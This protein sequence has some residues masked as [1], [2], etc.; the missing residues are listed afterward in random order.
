MNTLLPKTVSVSDLQR[1]YTSVLNLLNKEEG[2]VLVMRKNKIQAILVSP[3][4]YALY[5]ETLEKLELE[6]ALRAVKTYKSEKK[7]GKLKKMNSPN[8]LFE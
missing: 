3:D 8:E 4:S 2:P 5:M 7:R 1:D 6:Q